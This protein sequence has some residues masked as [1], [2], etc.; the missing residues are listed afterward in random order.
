MRRC[1]ENPPVIVLSLWC[2]A[3][4]ANL[5]NASVRSCLPRPACYSVDAE[6]RHLL[7]CFGLWGIGLMFEEIHD[8]LTALHLDVPRGASL[9]EKM[10]VVSPLIVCLVL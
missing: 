9:G 1:V 5:T 7:R 6:Q 10:D 2:L 4:V 8:N 3:L